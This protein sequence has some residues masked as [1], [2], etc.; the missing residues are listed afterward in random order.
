MD[1]PLIVSALPSRRTDLVGA[2]GTPRRGLLCQHVALGTCDQWGCIIADEGV[3]ASS[4]PVT[5]A[6]QSDDRSLDI[7]SVPASPRAAQTDISSIRFWSRTFDERDEAFAHLRRTA[8]VSWHPPLETPGLRH[9]ESG[10][11][12]ITSAELIREVS[13]DSGRFSSERRQVSVRPTPFRI[14]PNML[15][16]D[17]PDHALYRGA[18]A[19]TFAPAHL[20]RLGA[21]IAR[22]VRQIVLRSTFQSEFDLV[23]GIAA[24]V[25]AR[26]LAVL[27]DIPTPE[28]PRFLVAVDAFAGASVP[29]LPQHELEAWFGAQAGYLESLVDELQRLRRREPA[30]DLISLLVNGDDAQRLGPASL[31]STVLLLIVAG[32]DTM[33]QLITLSVLALDR[34]PAERAWLLVDFDA[35]FDRAFD[36]L[37]RFASPVLS[38][39][40]TATTDVELGGVRIRAGEKVALFYCSGNRDEQLFDDAASLRLA[41]GS[42]RHVAFGGGG[43]HFCLGSTLARM[44]LRAVLSTLFDRMP[45]LRAGAPVF[46]FDDAVHRVDSLPIRRG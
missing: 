46:A 13:R 41:R 35:R 19:A 26:V 24:G 1:G 11:W 15:V 27:L 18:V 43:V 2:S 17:P 29:D 22:A 12:A 28:I 36:E 9:D 6:P 8:P 31:R 10:F 16:T 45:D 23:P 30:D 32:H 44:Q 37:V 42:N 20:R 25:P 3:H 5:G 21:Q 7:V 4:Y 34:N 33:K 38:F 39:A 40:R 14:M